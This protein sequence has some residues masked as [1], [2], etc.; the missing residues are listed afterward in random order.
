MADPAVWGVPPGYEDDGNRWHDAPPSTVQAV[1]EAMGA[2]DAG[3]PAPRAWVVTAGSAVAP[4]AAEARLDLIA[5][6]AQGKA[7]NADRRIDRDAVWALKRAALER[8]WARFGGDPAF[9]R[10]CDDEGPALAAYATWCA[11]AEEQRRPWTEW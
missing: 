2:D 7:L 4:G 6:S 10:Y 11:I 8:L 3:P 5:L 1:L 9:D